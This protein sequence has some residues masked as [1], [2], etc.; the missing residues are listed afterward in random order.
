MEIVA[1]IQKK[2]ELKTQPMQDGISI[3][4]PGIPG[5]PTAMFRV[6]LTKEV[7]EEL[8]ADWFQIKQANSVASD[9]GST[10]K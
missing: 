8:Q 7:M 9:G 1:V 6:V 2:E 10:D 4:I 3:L 5:T